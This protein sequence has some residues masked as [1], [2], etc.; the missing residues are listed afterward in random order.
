MATNLEFISSFDSGSGNSA[1]SCDNVFSDKYSSYFVTLRAGYS[2]QGYVSL[3]FIDSAG[4]VETSATYDTAA[5]MLRSSA[6]FQEYRLVNN[7]QMGRINYTYNNAIGG[8]TSFYVHNPYDSSSYTFA[9][10]QNGFES[11]GYMWGIKGIGVEKT[12]QTIRGFQIFS[13]GEIR[14]NKIAVYGVK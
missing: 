13:G 6:A 2:V 3:R 5:L 11:E 4:A 8:D 14:D 12:A 10:W 7:D 1:I 9:Q